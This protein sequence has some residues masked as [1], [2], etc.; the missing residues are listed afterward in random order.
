MSMSL[1]MIHPQ[2]IIVCCVPTVLCANG[3]RILK[4]VF[5]RN[6][7]FHVHVQIVV[8]VTDN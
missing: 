1:S 3:L 7:F 6:G 8:V 5:G 2:G 4:L